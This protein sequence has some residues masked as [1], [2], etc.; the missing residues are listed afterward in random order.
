MTCRAWIHVG[1]SEGTATPIVIVSPGTEMMLEPGE[2]RVSCALDALPLPRGRYYIW[3][4]ANRYTRD[5]EELVAWQPVTPFDVYGPDL[6][7][8]PLGVV[9]LAPIH[10]GSTWELGTP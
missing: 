1:I 10:V 8:P 4:A 5:G 3:V 7:A 2:T 9:R 6:T